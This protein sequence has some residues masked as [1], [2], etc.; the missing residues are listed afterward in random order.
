[1]LVAD[2]EVRER[3]PGLIPAVCLGWAVTLG[4]VESGRGWIPEVGRG[5]LYK[6][7]TGGTPGRGKN[8]VEHSNTGEGISK[9]LKI[10][11][12]PLYGVS[13]GGRPRYYW[14]VVVLRMAE[15]RPG[16]FSWGR[17]L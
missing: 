5:G 13:L 2:I 14:V 16:R 15:K 11:N 3:D 7:K 8:F 4:G 12:G 10:V 9:K 17:G 6:K 1:L